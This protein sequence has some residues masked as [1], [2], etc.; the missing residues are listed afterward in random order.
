VEVVPIEPG[1][2]VD[3]DG[4]GPDRANRW[5]D[6]HSHGQIRVVRVPGFLLLLPLVMMAIGLVLF[7]KVL[8]VFLLSVIG[9][10]I[11]LSR[12]R[13]VRLAVVQWFVR[14]LSTRRGNR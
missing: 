8:G 13:V 1:G 4:T 7:F 3:R 5:R 2:T 14:Q 12:L 10:F 9:I 6:G 11:L